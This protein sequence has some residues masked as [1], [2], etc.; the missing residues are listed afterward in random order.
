MDLVG[1]AVAHSGDDSG[2]E[3]SQNES[4]G[5]R[6]VTESGAKQNP[7]ALFFRAT[8][9]RLGGR[10]HFPKDLDAIRLE[11][12]GESFAAFRRMVVDLTAERPAQP[13]AI[14]QVR[15]R[16][17]NLSPGANRLLSRIPMPLIAAQPGFRSKTWLLGEDS[18]DFIGYY[19]FDTV[20]AAEAYWDSLPLRMMRKRAAKGSLTHTITPLSPGGADHA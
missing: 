1:V 10:V 20:A 2:S 18:G 7:I 6:T 13:G 15:F 19:E 3:T 9:L 12:R 4:R 14:F 11:D 5:T 17:K 8:R 16:F